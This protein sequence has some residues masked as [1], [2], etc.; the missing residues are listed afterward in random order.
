MREVVHVEDGIHR[1]ALAAQFLDMIDALPVGG[2]HHRGAGHLIEA[3]GSDVDR[4]LGDTLPR[5]AAGVVVHIHDILLPDAYPESWG[6]R[7]YNEQNGAGALLQAGYEPLFASR[8]AVTRMAG[9]LAATVVARLPLVAGAW[10]SG[11][12]LRK[13]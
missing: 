8:Y 1:R 13:T 10:E 11:L 2:P 5:L 9:D 7:G 3:P 4:L 12:W 6:W